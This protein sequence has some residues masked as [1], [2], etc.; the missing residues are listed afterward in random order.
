MALTLTK[1]KKKVK[2]AIT[3][4]RVRLRTRNFTAEALREKLYTT[5]FPKLAVVRLGSLTPV[6][7]ITGIRDVIEINKPEAIEISRDK[8]LMKEAFTKVGVKTANWWIYNNGEFSFQTTGESIS[9]SINALEYPILSKSRTGQGGSGNTLHRDQKSLEDWMKGKNLS[10]YIFEEFYNYA[11]EYRLHVTQE[12]TFLVWRKMRK[13]DAKDR[14]Y[15]NSDNCVWI[16]EENPLFDKP[17]NWDDCIQ[18]CVLALKSVGLD[19]GAV[20]IRIQS[21]EDK[22]GNK[23]KTCDFIVLE[24]GSAPALGTVGS[25]FY[26]KEIVKLINKKL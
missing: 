9:K 6:E 11:R 4:F 7:E 15:F 22:D 25:E 20:D 5:F 24:T 1:P 12:G 2:K 21:S 8:K 26:Y 13:S 3:S 14:W 16:G 23:R 17:I 18:Q 19:I 10:N